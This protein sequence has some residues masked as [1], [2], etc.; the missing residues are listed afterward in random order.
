MVAR[1]WK[2]ERKCVGE[3]RFLWL[4]LARA[5]ES[6]HLCFTCPGLFASFVR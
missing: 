3:P 5:R 6:R 1:F 2:K 4:A